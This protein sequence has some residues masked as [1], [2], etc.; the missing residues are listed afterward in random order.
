MKQASNGWILIIDADERIPKSLAEN[1]NN[2]A[3]RDRVDAVEMP[4]KN[5]IGDQ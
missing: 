3:E 2:V 4:H 5:L 1:L